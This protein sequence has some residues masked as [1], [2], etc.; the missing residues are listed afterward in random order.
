MSKKNQPT[1][2]VNSIIRP[3]TSI[4]ARLTAL[5]TISS[6][7]ASIA[8]T[9]NDAKCAKHHLEEARCQNR[10]VEVIVSDGK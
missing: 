9:I 6:E 4:F 1:R 2:D 5:D 7:A 3:L 10:S 8:K